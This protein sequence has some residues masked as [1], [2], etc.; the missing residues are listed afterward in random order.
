MVVCVRKNGP[1]KSQ[2]GLCKVLV[3]SHIETC[4]NHGEWMWMCVY[5]RETDRQTERR[6]RESMCGCVECELIYNVYVYKIR[7]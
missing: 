5:E 3:F 4:G 7:I 1:C 2:E 6:G